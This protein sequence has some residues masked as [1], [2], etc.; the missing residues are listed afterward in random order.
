[1]NRLDNLNGPEYGHVRGKASA[2]D[3]S[4]ESKFFGGNRIS[5]QRVFPTSPHPLLLLPVVLSGFSLFGILGLAETFHSS[6]TRD[7]VLLIAL[8]L[9]GLVGSVGTFLCGRFIRNRSQQW[10]VFGLRK[11]A[12]LVLICLA[13]LIGL[14]C[15]IVMAHVAAP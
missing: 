13:W 6:S 11:T 3:S 5:L 4:S 15:G 12:W 1:V 14:A 10:Q 9:V 7:Q 2:H 8:S